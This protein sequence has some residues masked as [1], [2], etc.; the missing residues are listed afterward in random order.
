MLLHNFSG[1]YM[2]R[3][4][5]FFVELLGHASNLIIPHNITEKFKGL[6][7]HFYTGRLKSRMNCMNGLFLGRTVLKGGKYIS[8]GKA[9]SIARNSVITAWDKR[10][11]LCYAPSIKIGCNCCL[12]ECIHIS[13]VDKV[14]IGDGV[15]TGRRV[16]IVDND[17]GSFVYDQLR[18]PPIQRP[19]SYKEVV[20]GN[21]VWIGDK[22]TI[23][24]G[25][26]I[27]DGAVIAAN[28]VV[29]KDIPAYSLAGGIPAKV[30]KTL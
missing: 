17:H 1:V 10:D 23:T 22:V 28:A 20:I 15:L 16:T 6:Y 12:G 8:V 5:I 7:A 25:V 30:I 21:N 19:L 14:V 11:N 2:E 27:G 9:T 24:K 3:F 4:V 26:H 18:L 13:A 29:T